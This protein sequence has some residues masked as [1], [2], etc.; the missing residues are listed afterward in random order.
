MLEYAALRVLGDNPVAVFQQDS[1]RYVSP[2][3][4]GPAEP[5][6]SLLILSQDPEKWVNGHGL[7]DIAL[8]LG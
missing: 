1:D 7:W 5:S 6:R 4:S 2:S 8:T 3:F